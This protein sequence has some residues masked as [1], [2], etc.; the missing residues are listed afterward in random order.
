MADTDQGEKGLFYKS[1]EFICVFVLYSMSH[2][3]QVLTD[4]ESK[5]WYR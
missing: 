5:M 4:E 3:R 1:Q 2:G